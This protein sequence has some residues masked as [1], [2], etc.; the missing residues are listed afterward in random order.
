MPNESEVFG[1]AGS[2]TGSAGSASVSGGA[3]GAA[4]MIGDAGS[5]D[6]GGAESPAGGGGAVNNSSGG[7]ASSGAT[8][9][10]GAGGSL[11]SSGASGSSA[12]DPAAGLVAH[13]TF[14][15]PSGATAANA[16]DA[17]KNAKCVGTC[18]RPTGQLGLAFGVRNSVSP[19]DWI[20]LPE[21]IFSGHSAVTLSVWLR[22][23]STTRNVAPLFHFSLGSNEAISLVPDDRNT[24]TSTAGAH[25]A[26]VHAGTSFVDLW[27][28]TPVLTDKVW[29]HLAFSW[30]SSSIELY[31][32]G[33]SVGSAASPKALPSQL[34]ATLPNY[35]GRLPDDTSLALFGEIDDLRVYNRVLSTA[36]V[37]LLYAVR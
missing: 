16:K 35:L 15:E 22:V 37:A 4:G 5:G 33:K 14:D 18:T 1:S 27:S 24:Q 11:G 34:G 25:L 2:Q 36:Q 30:S 23:L 3:P 8:G 9:S 10:S 19:T 26:G 20:E 7:K 29:H 21:G 32:D 17:T 6:S 13:F 28:A 12:F 31:I